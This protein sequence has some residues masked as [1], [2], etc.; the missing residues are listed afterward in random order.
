MPAADPPAVAP[1]AVASGAI[2]AG[3]QTVPSRLAA[4]ARPEAAPAGS[5]RGA[6]PPTDQPSSARGVNGTSTTPP[7]ANSIRSFS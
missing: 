1:G 5:R 6:T 4:I 7:G 3:D 2:D